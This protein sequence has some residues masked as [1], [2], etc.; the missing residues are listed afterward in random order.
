MPPE[1]KYSISVFS[2]L[3]DSKVLFFTEVTIFYKTPSG[4]IFSLTADGNL[5]YY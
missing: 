5:E 1:I 3:F 2:P 4:K